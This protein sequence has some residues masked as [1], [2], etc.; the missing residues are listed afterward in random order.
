MKT[1]PALADLHPRLLAHIVAENDPSEGFCDLQNFYGTDD[2]EM[3]PEIVREM[4]GIFP[5]LSTEQ[6]ERI[7]AEWA[8]YPEIQAVARQLK[9][10]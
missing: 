6:V 2:L 5:A 7:V 3:I 8:G 4:A 9:T 1:Y 10:V